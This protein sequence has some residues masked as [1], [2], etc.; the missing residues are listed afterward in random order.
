MALHHVTFFFWQ[1]G[2]QCNMA[3]FSILYRTILTYVI[4]FPINGT[5]FV[6]NK[7]QRSSVLNTSKQLYDLYDKGGQ[8]E[9]VVVLDLVATL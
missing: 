3:A 6:M 7:Y 1:Y 5:Y 4:S 9:H 8:M 2:K